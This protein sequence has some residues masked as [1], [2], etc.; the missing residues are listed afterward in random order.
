MLTLDKTIQYLIEQELRDAV[1]RYGAEGGC[2]VVLD[3]K[4]GALLAL[5][6]Y[7]TYDPNRFAEIDEKRFVD[8]VIGRPYEP[9]STFK[10]ITMAAALEAGAVMW[11]M[12]TMT[13]ALSRSGG[14]PSKT[15]TKKH[16][17]L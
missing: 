2:I 9:G 5:A 7:P 13:W 12:C 8:P 14:G 11:P 15:G 17:A 1:E 16:M 6:S 3:P 10:V 4:T